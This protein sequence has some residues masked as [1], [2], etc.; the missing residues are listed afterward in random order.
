MAEHRHLQIAQFFKVCKEL[1]NYYCQ[2]SSIV[3][4]K[5]NQQRSHIIRAHNFIQHIQ[6][7]VDESSRKSMRSITKENIGVF[8]VIVRRNIHENLRYKSYIMKRSKFMS[9]NTKKIHLVR[10]KAFLNK[11]KF[12]LKKTCFVFFS[13]LN[14]NNFDQD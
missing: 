9:K 2:T 13:F 8:E 10:S 11:L 7:F 6:N 1:Q 14:E 12:L 4:R 3:K 5:R